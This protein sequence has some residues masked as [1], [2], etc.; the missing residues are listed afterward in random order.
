MPL[1]GGSRPSLAPPHVAVHDRAT[2]TRLLADSP[3]D[4]MYAM[5][6]RLTDGR[7]STYQ[8]VHAIQEHLQRR[9]TYT[10]SPP[11]HDYPLPAF[12][13]EDRSGYCQQFSGAMA[14]MLRMAG[15]P[16]RVAAGFSAGEPAA[17]NGEFAV[18][19]LDAHSWVEVYFNGIGWVAF[20][21]TPAIAPAESQTSGLGLL[22]F[23]TAVLGNKASRKVEGGSKGSEVKGSPVS[24][25]SQ[26]IPPWALPV[27]LLAALALAAGA[28][29][30]RA[31]R[32]RSLAPRAATEARLRELE[33]AVTRL[34]SW[35]VA[36]TTLLALER[37]L[38][39]IAC[40][41]A[42]R[43][44]ARLR[45]ARYARKDTGRFSG[46]DRRAMRRELTRGLGLRAR[47]RGFIAVPPGGPS[48]SARSG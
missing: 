26:G 12:L 39:S 2:V 43:Y 7:H 48:P 28:I 47:L 41:A 5:A 37:R 46:R 19:D 6:H 40:P 36:G 16:S 24:E 44:A 27:A 17:R 20:D 22:R 18:R 35:R 11:Q 34:R 23:P 8:V 13:F 42:A 1:R 29:A 25:P 21:P 4:R 45:E 9:Y 30:A 15:I 31:W 14:L 38:A 32:Y 10:E 3:Y 33:R